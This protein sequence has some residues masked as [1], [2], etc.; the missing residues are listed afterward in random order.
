MERAA[1]YFGYSMFWLSRILLFFIIIILLL[2]T[3]IVAC[4]LIHSHESAGIRTSIP[5]TA[6]D[7]ETVL[8]PSY[9]SSVPPIFLWFSIPRAQVLVE[10]FTLK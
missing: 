8:A 3:I 9:L 1:T 7:N 10:L 2:I 4:K 6:N 5:Q